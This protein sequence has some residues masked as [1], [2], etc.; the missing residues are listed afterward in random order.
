MASLSPIS[1]GRLLL[2][3]WLPVLVINITSSILSSIITITNYIFTF[4]YS[5]FT[6]INYV[7][8]LQY[9]KTSDEYKDSLRY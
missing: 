2:K 1:I 6:I 9:G 7:F 5:N 4:N 8:A 3:I